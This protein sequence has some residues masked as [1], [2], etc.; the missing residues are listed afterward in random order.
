MSLSRSDRTIKHNIDVPVIAQECRDR[1]NT[2]HM[3]LHEFLQESPE[4]EK[5]TTLDQATKL[6]ILNDATLHAVNKLQWAMTCIKENNHGEG[7]PPT[8]ER[9][10]E[11]K[12]EGEV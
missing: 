9:K 5:L 8:K 10:E 1:L 12:Q 11:T 4:L 6:L 7:Q 3:L 2:L